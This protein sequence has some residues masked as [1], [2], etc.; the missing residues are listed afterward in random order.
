[1]RGFKDA[2]HGACHVDSRMCSYIMLC[3]AT[4]FMFVFQSAMLDLDLL[5]ESP[6]SEGP[7][8]I[9]VLGR[10]G[11]YCYKNDTARGRYVV[12]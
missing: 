12:R 8:R 2:V 10:L 6:A 4:T 9:L 3:I 5:L 1:M 7:N 11:I